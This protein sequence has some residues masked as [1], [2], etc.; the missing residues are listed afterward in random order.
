MCLALVAFGAH[1]RYELVIAANRDEFHVRA[2]AAAEW[3]VE[4]WL[5]GRDL[6]GGGTWLGITRAGR[7]ALLTNVRE[8]ARYDPAAPTRGTLVPGIL[9]AAT[10]PRAALA[11]A[12]GGAQGYNGFNLLA[13]DRTSVHWGSNRADGPLALDHGIH[14]LSN[15][16]LDTPWP[17]VVRTRAALADWCAA[18]NADLEPVFG[19]LADRGI[20]PDA[21]LPATG[22]PLAR[23]RQLSPPF[24]VGDDY[25]TR[26]STVLAIARG[27]NARFVERSFDRRGCIA[28]EREHRFDIGPAPER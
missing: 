10:D 27:G 8:P 26:S 9:A 7:W 18:G 16:A 25:G 5:A 4:G 28:G 6:A 19:L 17:K 11:A 2:T 20:A 21:A 14:G 24:I 15:A 13:G 12:L 3:W 23:E 1:P 22:V